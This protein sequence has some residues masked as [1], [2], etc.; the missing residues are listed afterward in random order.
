M[1]PLTSDPY[2]SHATKLHTKLY[3]TVQPNVNSVLC[4]GAL[5]SSLAHRHPLNQAWIGKQEVNPDEI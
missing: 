4:P 1:F 2:L 3:L 5:M